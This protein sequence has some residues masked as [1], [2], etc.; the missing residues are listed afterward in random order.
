[1][2]TSDAQSDHTSRIPLRCFQCQ[3]F[4]H[5]KTVCRGQPQPALDVQRRCH[6]HSRLAKRRKSDGRSVALRPSSSGSL[7]GA[8]CEDLLTSLYLLELPWSK[9][10][11]CRSQIHHIHVPARMRCSSKE[12]F[13]KSTMTDASAWL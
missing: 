2:P 7:R 4:G 6:G 9:D 1:M 12:T 8:T 11:T 10:S 13:L 5:S 3:R